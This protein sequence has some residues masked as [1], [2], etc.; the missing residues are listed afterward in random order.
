MILRYT[1]KAGKPAV[2]AAFRLSVYY[3]NSTIVTPVSP[4]PYTPK[5]KVLTGVDCRRE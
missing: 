1:S 4:S 3:L 5:R 2:Y